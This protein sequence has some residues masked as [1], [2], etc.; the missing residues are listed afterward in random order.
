[1]PPPA[2]TVA[3]GGRHIVLAGACLAVL[4]ALV[5]LVLPREAT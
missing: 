4:A 3:G 2:A 5:S 1:V